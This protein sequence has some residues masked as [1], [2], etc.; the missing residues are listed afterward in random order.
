MSKPSQTATQKTLVDTVNR[1][2]VI[3]SEGMGARR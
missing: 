2:V 1:T 3:R